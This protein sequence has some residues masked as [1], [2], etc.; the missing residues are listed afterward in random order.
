MTFNAEIAEQF[1]PIRLLLLGDP[2]F[3]APVREAAP[4]EVDNVEFVC[5][6]RGESG[7]SVTR[8]S[9][10]AEAKQATGVEPA[11]TGESVKNLLGGANLISDVDDAEQTV[12]SWLSQSQL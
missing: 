6:Q 2:L 10:V 3:D 1:P 11:V 5:G 4:A 9:Q 7:L 8:S 12:L